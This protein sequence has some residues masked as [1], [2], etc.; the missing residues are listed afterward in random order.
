MAL[1]KGKDGVVT[2]TPDEGVETAVGQIQSWEVSEDID[3]T[4]GTSMGDTYRINV[5]MFNNFS[6]NVSALWDP[7]DGGQSALTGGATGDIAIY[8]QGR[9]AG[10]AKISGPVTINNRSRTADKDGLVG[11]SIQFQSRGAITEGTDV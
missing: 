2:F 9:G 4:D 1:W 3:T 10:M 8:P 5:P 6:G 7:G 11:V